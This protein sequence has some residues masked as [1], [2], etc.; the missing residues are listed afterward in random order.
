MKTAFCILT[1][2][3]MVGCNAKPRADKSTHPRS[4]RPYAAPPVAFDGDSKG[5]KQSVDHSHARCPDAR[6]EERGLVCDV[7]DGL[8]PSER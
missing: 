2:V 1:C 6:R 8:E 7:P 3:A 4:N 5:L